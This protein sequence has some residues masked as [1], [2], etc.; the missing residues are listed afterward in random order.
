MGFLRKIFRGKLESKDIERMKDE[1]DLKGLIMAMGDPFISIRSQATEA[2]GEL[3]DPHA[4]K[5][6]II[7]AGD[8][9]SVLSGK[10]EEAMIKIGEPAVADLIEFLQSKREKT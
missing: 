9:D 4:V 10:A 8:S 5:G 3:G 7:T 6:L 1:R 2:L